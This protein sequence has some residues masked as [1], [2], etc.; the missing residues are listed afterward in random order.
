[1]DDLPKQ[2]SFSFPLYHLIKFRTISLL[3]ELSSSFSS[4]RHQSVP[5]TPDPTCSECMVSAVETFQHDSMT[6]SAPPGPGEAGKQ[7]S[8]EHR[9]PERHLQL[10]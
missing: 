5:E 3:H 10:M 1:M 2:D 9:N 8:P 6:M 7:L 4:G